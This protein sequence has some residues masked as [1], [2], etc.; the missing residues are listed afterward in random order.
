MIVFIIYAISIY[1]I[2]GMLMGMNTFSV[3]KQQGYQA[4]IRE[5][6]VRIPIFW[7][8]DIIYNV[9]FTYNQHNGEDDG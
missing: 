4:P 1:L 8:V 9:F 7:I 6:T 2:V 3:D 5:Y